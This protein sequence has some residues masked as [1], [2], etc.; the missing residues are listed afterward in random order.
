M[1]APHLV[2]VGTKS[3]SL[4]RAMPTSVM[5]TK[6]CY[7]DCNCPAKSHVK[8]DKLDIKPGLYVKASGKGKLAY[9]IPYI[10]MEFVINKGYAKELIELSMGRS[11]RDWGLLFQLVNLDQGNFSSLSELEVGLLDLKTSAAGFKTPKKVSNS[12]NSTSKNELNSELF[13][14]DEKVKP[15]SNLDFFRSKMMSTLGLDKEE[16]GPE[17]L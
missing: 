14:E 2:L 4:C 5:G 11:L 8:A 1:N 15:M 16:V 9:V 13:P 17:Q 7:D 12:T 6:W 3:S 10:P